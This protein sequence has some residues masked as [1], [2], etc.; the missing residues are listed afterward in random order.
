MDERPGPGR[1]RGPRPLAMH[2][3]LAALTL[4]G[5]SD[6]LP[7]WNDDWTSW[8]ARLQ[9][10]DAAESP[11]PPPVDRALLAGIAAYRRHPY[12][13]DVS[14]PP[15]V[16][17]CGATRLLDYGG[18]GPALLLVPSLVNRFTV[19]DLSADRSMARFLVASGFH[20]LLLDWG[21]PGAAEAALDL[22]ALITGRLLPVIAAL[23]PVILVGYCMGGLLTLAAGLHAPQVR[24]VALLATPWDFQTGDA[25]TV[26]AGARLFAQLAPV[27]EL[28]GRLPVDVLQALFSLGDPPSVAAKYRAFAA[29]PQDSARA[30][31]F[32]A[33]ED[34][35]N[36]GVPLSAPVARDCLQGWY[37]ENRP[38]RGAWTV[39]G[40]AVD[41]AQLR[42]PSFI[43]IPGRDRIVPP[44]SAEPLARLIA[45]AVVHRPSAGHVG[46]VAGGDAEQALWRPLA[47]WA[48]AVAGP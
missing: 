4:H 7:S 17:S 2:L 3:G 1:R 16:W 34:W 38:M 23:G 24:G 35:L 25:E 36:D 48:H 26:A 28:H 13:R 45:G 46:M 43:A 11:L 29:M 14:D 8:L 27:L 33:L 5:S 44:E 22:D 32:V 10:P 37:A 41:P 6:G 42:V 18:S 30:R 40:A 20:V 9:S 19:L 21:W 47:S 39:A 31:Q 15:S 12:V